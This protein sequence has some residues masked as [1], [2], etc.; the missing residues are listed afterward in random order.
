MDINKIYN[1]ND[2]FNLM[3]L[4]YDLII[5]RKWSLYKVS[6][7]FGNVNNYTEESKV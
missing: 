7:S 6:D 4:Y 2:F 5:T 1:E 3:M